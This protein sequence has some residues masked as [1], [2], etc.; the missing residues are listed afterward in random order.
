MKVLVTGANGHLG[1]N[2][3]RVAL[4]EGHEVRAMVRATSDTTSLDGLEVERVLGDILDPTSLP[5]A[6][7]GVDWVLHAAAVYRN[8]AA[9]PEKAILE[10]AVKGTENVL[11]AASVAGVKRVV[12]TSSIAT[13]GYGEDR[14]VL[15]ESH[16]MQDPQSAYIRAKCDQERVALALAEEL[17]LELVV[18]CPGGN[19]GPWDVGLTPAT[20]SVV[21]LCTGDPAPLD[22]C[23]T[24]IEDIARGHLL[25]AAN[26]EAGERYLLTGDNLTNQQVAELMSE[27]TGRKVRAMVPPRWLMRLIA[28]NEVRKARNGSVDD[29]GITGPQVADVYGKALWY[30]SSRAKNELGWQ[31]RDARSTVLDTLSWLASQ[32]H[33]PGDVA[34]RVLSERPADPSWP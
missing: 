32:G 7:A 2:L 13:V 29:A 21:N 26:G 28:W 19:L 34:E 33:L 4:A 31:A 10:P 8:W 25:A 27:L 11:R 16:H 14:A 22:L 30:D 1:A 3:V 23:V 18:V 12:L 17:G 24:H 20:R 6:M 15:D 5:A 9:D